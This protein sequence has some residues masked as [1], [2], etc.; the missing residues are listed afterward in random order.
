MDGLRNILTFLAIGRSCDDLCTNYL[1]VWESSA[2][3][4]R[5]QGLTL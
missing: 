1:A 3:F 5:I 4:P 2:I